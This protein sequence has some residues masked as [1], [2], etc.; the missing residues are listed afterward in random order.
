MKIFLPIIAL[1]NRLKYIQKFAVIGGILGIPIL[2]MS[3]MLLSTTNKEID[4]I[5]KRQVGTEYNTL[6][7][8]FLQD[9]QQHRA[10][11]VSV[12]S[13]D[14][15]DKPKLEEKQAEIQEDIAN[16]DAFVKG[17]G[18][19]IQVSD[20]W[21]EMKQQWNTLQS[22]VESLKLQ[23]ATSRHIDYLGNILDFMVEVGDQSE[24]FL[25]KAPENYY[26]INDVTTT[27]PN[28]T[29][30]LG[31]IRAVGMSIAAEQKITDDQ[32]IQLVSLYASVQNSL[33]LLEHGK[34]II[35]TNKPSLENSLGE[36]SQSTL[37]ETN[38]FLEF[39][40]KEFSTN[41]SIT[42]N[43]DEF[44][45]MATATID[46]SFKLYELETK[47]LN[48]IM[49]QQAKDL[50]LTKAAIIAVVVLI[51]ILTIYI[52]VGF[53]LSISSTVQKLKAVTIH[54]ADG[55]LETELDLQTKDEMK[56]VETAFNDMIQNLR[57][58]IHHIKSSAEHLAS[59]SAELS[60][61]AEQ[62]SRASEQITLTVQDV[63]A[64]TEKQVESV[65]DSSTVV[66]EVSAGIQQVAANAQSVT[67]TAANASTNAAD[68]EQAI[69]VAVNQMN[70][71]NHSVNDAALVVKEL[72]A[73]SLQIGEIVDVITNIAGQTNL[74]ALNAAIEAARAGQHGQGFAVVADEVRKLAEQSASSAQQIGQL[75]TS[76][77]KETE[78]AVQTM[79][80]A[81]AEVT[82][83]ITAISTA[84]N[85]FAE[86]KGSVSEVAEQI[87]QVSAAA[88]QMLVGAEQVVGSIE[89][90]SEIAQVS[91][92][93]TQNISS[94]TEE[95]L[96]SM[97]EIEASS[98]TLSR[99]AEELQETVSK[100][101]V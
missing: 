92:E 84:G 41:T 28:L 30:H 4:T 91:S 50:K 36:A 46:T 35:F 38:K 55:D 33:E 67:V 15:S 54:V 14:S 65:N 48:S 12:I 71:I 78:K 25:A 44:Y 85:S 52:F 16:M 60:A 3:F 76:I 37:E 86:I 9:V 34:A 58:L 31:Q 32:K 56:D 24:L 11:S 72:G 7:K 10:I 6:L 97:E 90:I 87:G 17:T 95:Q 1:M 89:V 39:V 61:S 74:L 99:L 20:Q 26:I 63:A 83:G 88:Q 57:S 66:N 53:Y 94:I 69:Q 18:S 73:R 29:E 21:A 75:I 27:L 8:D 82:D 100:F 62:T 51:F 68:G 45:N 93:G 101:K 77:Q 79:N 64:G 98:I 5:Q 22:D 2:I 70:S 43:T 40:Q 59:S 19:S 13:G 23:E 49:T 47:A 81:T 80:A 96:A 42:V